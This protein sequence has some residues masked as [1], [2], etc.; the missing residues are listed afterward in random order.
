MLLICAE[1]TIGFIN[2]PYEVD[3]DD[4]FATVEFGITS[5]IIGPSVSLSIEL[6]FSDQT[7]I[8]KY[9]KTTY[10]LTSILLTLQMAVIMRILDLKFLLSTLPH[11]PTQSMCQFSMMLYWNPIK[12]FRPI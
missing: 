6:Y 9:F 4:D 5:G 1:L 11:L 7:A 10:V 3:E 8:S 12:L 2:A